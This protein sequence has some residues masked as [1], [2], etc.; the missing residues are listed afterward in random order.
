LENKEIT[1]SWPAAAAAA[2]TNKEQPAR[3][4]IR[5]EPEKAIKRY[6]PTRKLKGNLKLI[7]DE[8]R[9]RKEKEE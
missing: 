8:A 9:K 3:K 2:A 5:K 6:R 4:E 7:A 1:W